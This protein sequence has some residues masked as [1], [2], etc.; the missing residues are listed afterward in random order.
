MNNRERFFNLLENKDIDR[1]PF[2]PDISSWYE[3]SRKDSGEEE[4][5]GPGGYIPDGIDFHKQ[6]SHLK[7]K[8]AKMTFLDFY[9]QY[10]WG[11]PVHIGEEDWFKIE[12]SGGIERTVI[13][14]E[15]RKK[16]I[17]YK[18]PRGTINRIYQLAGD[19]S[20]APRSYFIKEF[21]DIDVIKYIFEHRKLI[22]QFEKVTQFHRETE[23]FGICDLVLWRSP[24]GK[25]I[26]EYMGFEKVIYALYD[27][28]KVILDFLEFLEEYDL[29]VVKLAAQSP[30]KLIIIS[31][32]ADE[33]LISPAYYKKYC[34]PYYQKACAILHKNYK[35]VSTHLDGNFK[36]YF[37]FIKQTHFDLL[38]GCTPAPMFNYDVEELA[39]ISD[40]ELHCYCGVPATLLTQ[41][42][43]TVELVHFG[44][45]I[46]KAFER[47]VLV[48]IG[49]ILPSNGNIEQVIEIGK[50]VINY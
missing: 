19:G 26:H 10:D 17:T 45:R 40:D 29:E 32:H 25:L 35:Y 30:A 28:E 37:P 13:R 22:P 12:Y 5:F 41:N 24:F 38:D 48:N 16:I 14:N 20:W 43:E 42:I 47:R 44:L 46:A 21:E 49:D 3:Y 6:P 2:F 7:G 9:R 18:T 34:I 31:D 36:S 8:L 50:A 33:T 1:T 11:L 27:N 15:Y 39:E 4:T 23:G